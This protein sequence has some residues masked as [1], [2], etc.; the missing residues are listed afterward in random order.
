MHHAAIAASL[1]A[2]ELKRGLEHVNK[3]MSSLP[4]FQGGGPRK[5]VACIF[6]PRFPGRALPNVPARKAQKGTY[7]G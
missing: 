7:P 3:E 4:P 2:A 6:H 5:L 1:S